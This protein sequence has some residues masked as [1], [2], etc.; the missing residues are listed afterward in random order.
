MTDEIE[1]LEKIVDYDKLNEL[2]EIPEGRQIIR[3][4][5]DS[6]ESTHVSFT[7]ITDDSE[8]YS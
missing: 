3:I 1:K 2:F 4:I 7:I 8:K 6:M 5:P